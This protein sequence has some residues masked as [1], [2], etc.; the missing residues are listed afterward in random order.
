MN[1]FVRG[2]LSFRESMLS[3]IFPNNTGKK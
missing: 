3:A 1:A 2:H